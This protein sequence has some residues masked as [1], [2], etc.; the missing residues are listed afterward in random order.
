MLWAGARGRPR[1]ASAQYEFTLQCNCEESHGNNTTFFASTKATQVIRALDIFPKPRLPPSRRNYPHFRA[2]KA[3]RHP[4]RTPYVSNKPNQRSTLTRG[5]DTKQ[6]GLLVD[7]RQHRNRGS[8]ELVIKDTTKSNEQKRK[9]ASQSVQMTCT[10]ENKIPALQ[11][12]TRFTK[13][14]ESNMTDGTSINAASHASNAHETYSKTKDGSADRVYAF[15]NASSCSLPRNAAPR[16]FD[17]SSFL[18]REKK[19]RTKTT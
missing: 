17:L 12:S 6:E 16:Q 7:T 15:M 2:Y 8:G 14:R 9:E 3:V 19:S 5:M 10:R 18:P 1:A 11:Q 13:L 4:H